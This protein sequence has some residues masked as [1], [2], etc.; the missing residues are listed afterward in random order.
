MNSMKPNQSKTGIELINLERKRQVSEEGWTLKHDIQ[1]HCQKEIAESASCCLQSYI[2]GV[3]N[4]HPTSTDDSWG[5][6]RKHN[7]NPKRLLVIAGALIAAELD[8]LQRMS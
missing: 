3:G 5:L 6:A 8:R 2:N 4:Y 7:R 1:W